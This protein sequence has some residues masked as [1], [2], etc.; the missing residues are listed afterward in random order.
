MRSQTSL[1]MSNHVLFP[2][3]D[4]NSILFLFE[5]NQLELNFVLEGL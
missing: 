4:F 1:R 5:I 3:N 2:S